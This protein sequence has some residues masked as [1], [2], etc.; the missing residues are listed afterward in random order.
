MWRR[1][2]HPPP[3]SEDRIHVW[4]TSLECPDEHLPEMRELL[5]DYELTRADRFKFDRHRRRFI[6]GR[7][8]L[9]RLLGM[10]LG[11]E[12]GDLVF[13]YSGHGKPSLGASWLSFNVSNSHEL[14][15]LAFTRGRRVGIDVEHLRPM[16]DALK[17]AA[18]FFAANETD[19]LRAAAP[20]QVQSVFF[21]TWTRKEAILKASGEGL[22]RPLNS[23]DV[24]P[25][26][27]P[28][29][30]TVP[31]GHG[32]ATSWRLIDLVPGEGYTGAIA[33]DGEPFAAECF[34]WAPRDIESD[35]GIC[36]G[37]PRII[38]T[39][40]PVWVLEQMRRLGATEATI[41]ASYPTL[42]AEDLVH[43]W[44][45]VDLHRKEIDEQIRQNEED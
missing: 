34:E 19:A 36:G 35:P 38:G 12:P 42:R 40:I 44:S 16:P 26:L 6:V 3:I 30:V 14:A 13:E 7:A 17:L 23:F 43:A 32:V 37:D 11:A 4:K 39:R 5:D 18:R 1:C 10:Y 15:L 21:R 8:A 41:L 2:D 33:A 24:S 27:G 28:L 9:R 29:D 45:Y 31:D 20:D 25:P 22:S